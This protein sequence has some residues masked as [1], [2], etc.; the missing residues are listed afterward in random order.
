MATQTQP[1]ILGVTEEP[2]PILDGT[3]YIAPRTGGAIDMG[4]IGVGSGEKL[5]SQQV[6]EM[7]EQPNEIDSFPRIAQIMIKRDTLLNTMF[8]SDPELADLVAS[9]SDE[10]ME[11]YSKELRNTINESD[12]EIAALNL[13][14]K[15]AGLAGLVMNNPEIQ[16]DLVESVIEGVKQGKK[17]R[18]DSLLERAANRVALNVLEGFSGILDPTKGTEIGATLK[19][20]F[21]SGDIDA[22]KERLEIAI[23]EKERRDKG[24]ERGLLERATLRLKLSSRPIV[25]TTGDT[26][27][28][29]AAGLAALSDERLNEII[30]R[31]KQV[32]EGTPKKEALSTLAT[33]AG[34]L[35]YIQDDSGVAQK[36]TDFITQIGGASASMTSLIPVGRARTLYKQFLRHGAAAAGA[37]LALEPAIQA[38]GEATGQIGDMTTGEKAAGA[39][40]R[41]GMAFVGGGALG[42]AIDAPTILRSKSS[43]QLSKFTKQLEEKMAEARAEKDV[44]K[45]ARL[46]VQ[47]AK[48]KEV[49]DTLVMPKEEI[50]ATPDFLTGQDRLLDLQYQ[51]RLAAAKT[52]EEFSK[53]ATEYDNFILDKTRERL[54]TG[55][56][57]GDVKDIPIK[58]RTQEI[59]RQ[60]MVDTLRIPEEELQITFDALPEAE[61]AQF[62]Q[63][64][65]AAKTTEELNAASK[66]LDDYILAKTK[67]RLELGPI[68]VT[69]EITPL[70]NLGALRDVPINVRSL[71]VSE[72]I[73]LAVRGIE[74]TPQAARQ[75]L[76]EAELLRQRLAQEEALVTEQEALAQAELSPK[77]PVGAQLLRQQLMREQRLADDA[78]IVSQATEQRLSE[79]PIR[80]PERTRAF[81]EVVELE[82]PPVFTPR[83]APAASPTVPE[84][85]PVQQIP[86]AEVP[87]LFGPKG[88]VIS[89]QKL[90]EV[91]PQVGEGGVPIIDVP[92]VK[93]QES[94]IIIGSKAEK[95][96]TDRIADQ[97]GRLSSGL[98]P[99]LFIAHTIKGA[100]LVERGVRNFTKWSKA[101]IDEVGQEI[102][103]YL[104]SIWDA[105]QK[106]SVDDV[107]NAAEQARIKSSPIEQRIINQK[108]Y[109]ESVLPET[110]IIFRRQIIDP[111]DEQSVPVEKIG[112]E[113]FKG[114]PQEQALGFVTGKEMMEIPGMLKSRADALRIRIQDAN[115]KIKRIQQ[116]PNVVIKDNANPYRAKELYFGRRT[117]RIQNII[118]SIEDFRTT[119]AKWASAGPN[120]NLDTL[121]KK[122]NDLAVNMHAPQRNAAGK[123]SGITD[124]DAAA[125]VREILNDP[126]YGKAAQQLAAEMKRLNRLTLDTLLDG[127]LI[128]QKQYDNFVKIYPDHVP[129]RRI[130]P[131]EDVDDY[132]EIL[133]SGPGL[134]VKSTGIKA[135][136]GSKL[137]IQEV[138]PNI[139]AN[140]VDAT[141]RAEKNTVNLETVRFW[142]NNKDTP[143]GDMVEIIPTFP[144]MKVKDDRSL[145]FY[146]KGKRKILKFKDPELAKAYQSLNVEDLP[147]WASLYKSGMVLWSQ[148]LTRFSLNFMAG[149]IVRDTQDAIANTLMLTDS[150]GKAGRLL[151]LQPSSMKT[152]LAAVRGKGGDPELVKL[153][154][155]MKMDG[156]TTGGL[157]LSTRKDVEDMVSDI[158]SGNKGKVKKGLDKLVKVVDSTNEIMENASRFSIY[159]IMLSSG[160]TRKEAADVAKNI[161]VNF[162]RKG[163][164]SP[165]VNALYMFFQ[166]SLNGTY[167]VAKL[168]VNR[169]KKA[170]QIVGA[171]AAA[172]FIT[173]QINDALNP[174]WRTD[175]TETQWKKNFNIIIPTDEGGV[176]R[177]SLPTGYSLYPMKVFNAVVLKARDE[178]LKGKV[179]TAADYSDMAQTV[180]AATLEAYSPMG[181]GDLIQVV[182]PSLADPF[183]DVLRNRA[184]DGSQVYPKAYG[185]VRRSELFFPDQ[186]NT[187]LGDLTIR[188]SKTLSEMGWEVSPESIEYI[189]RSFSG[190]PGQLAGNLV[191]MLESL[192]KREMPDAAMLPVINRFVG[193]VDPERIQNRLYNSDDLKKARQEV[194]TEKYIAR[195]E[196]K[197]WA[198]EVAE[199]ATSGQEVMAFLDEAQASGL[200][201][202]PKGIYDKRLRDSAMDIIIDEVKRK[203]EK[204]PQAAEIR[205][206]ERLT[207][208]QRARLFA[209]E[210]LN[211]RTDAERQQ[212]IQKRIADGTLDDATADAFLLEI[213]RLQAEGKLK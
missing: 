151:Y 165:A 65:A 181:A 195:R 194:D 107:L 133:T 136:K 159:R 127:Q 19:Q 170:A 192:A 21:T 167:N 38:A 57:L 100:A 53:I 135:A 177:L 84:R 211:L 48:L 112:I 81:G 175:I 212:Y 33:L 113:K 20:R 80:M 124:A 147:E 49:V 23:N 59:K 183:V 90:S 7:F 179:H 205:S 152:I 141:N 52:D 129:F 68:E 39:L 79:M 203:R 197:G 104:K 89:T 26:Q 24:Q 44:A 78:G 176:V 188:A 93:A 97:G 140:L 208:A 132:V 13:I 14:E 155:Q 210:L 56:I 1:D 54:Q 58:D 145:Y 186:K 46:E 154:N 82:R 196:I 213:K 199:K 50:E 60:R 22:A 122:A 76:T 156:G 207:S 15:N 148:A 125:T 158:M 2:N 153:Y 9:M 88:E 66:A 41:A 51:Q 172:E 157:A 28:A 202:Y 166:A 120:R 168:A 200:F 191:D 169:P 94:G 139:I 45:K 10:E 74:P 102:E 106:R 42:T 184:W 98:D 8:E 109:A 4:E 111:I 62:S 126:I 55:P 114:T 31:E 117:T 182:A 144:N 206:I 69:D 12:D 101:M 108:R 86:E 95:W 149:N 160:A 130:M 118:K 29:D 25:T 115:L 71:P 70:S 64:A 204:G 171:V 85:M 162:D 92:Q 35:A 163:T 36:V 67:E 173:N 178:V 116:R 161:T 201:N 209:N 121:L 146:D 128:S 103:P 123:D 189:A 119:A 137:E 150:W 75:Q 73:D 16:D 185:D 87:L 40:G 193:T 72:Q 110:D 174:N 3:Y 63:M 6:D 61:K 198:K 18:G 43:N 47:A 96:A 83:E 143:I 27:V 37:S 180:L 105:I 190:G 17:A 99:E 187:I 34:E 131:D 77:S 134:N 138:F 11:E 142:E 5:A 164:W 91:I 30:E 32:I